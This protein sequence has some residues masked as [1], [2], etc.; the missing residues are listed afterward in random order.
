MK[1]RYP[2]L[3]ELKEALK[4]IFSRPYTTKYP[5]GK[6][7]IHSRFRGKPEFQQDDCLACTACAE[8]CPPG[9]IEVIDDIENKKRRVVRY[10]DKCI[11]C[12]E[13][14]RICTCKSGVKMVPEFALAVYDRKDLVDTVE[15]ELLVCEKCGRPI[16][17]KKHILWLID[18]LQEK[19]A[20]QL[21]FIVMK[22]EE[23]GIAE[24]IK[25]KVSFDKRQDLF[26]I[27]CPK[28]RHRIML[29]DSL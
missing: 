20:V 8:V 1:M 7:D 17:T 18:Q 22:L 12:G 16:A 2:K 28:C 3:R 21:G 25:A 11:H 10:L 5:Y 19:G 4:Y 13:C 15:R 9:A 27:T 26:T 23:L 29:Y 14:E 6:A 24:D